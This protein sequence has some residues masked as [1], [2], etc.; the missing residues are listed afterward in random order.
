MGPRAPLGA[1]LPARP[2]LTGL[3]LAL[4]PPL[5]PFPQAGARPLEARALAAAAAAASQ[6]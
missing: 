6:G 3:P 1:A 4:S 2:R 5:P